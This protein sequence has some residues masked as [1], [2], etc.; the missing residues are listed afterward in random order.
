MLLPSEHEAMCKALQEAKVPLQETRVNPGKAG[1]SLTPALQA[2][3]S[4]SPELKV[5]SQ[6]CS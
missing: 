3:M 1:Q 2:L 4:K 6:C 5:G